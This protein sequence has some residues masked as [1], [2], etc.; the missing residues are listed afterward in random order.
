[1]PI[2]RSLRKRQS[3]TVRSAPLLLVLISSLM[4]CG[5]TTSAQGVDA[6]GFT[7][8]VDSVGVLLEI[9]N[10]LRE[11]NDILMAELSH[12]NDLLG[13]NEVPWYVNAWRSE[14]VRWVLFVLGVWFGIYASNQGS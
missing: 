1:M 2:S 13:I 4:L 8:P 12:K 10:S 7:A 9:N 6:L 14:P 3:S 11:A 5:T